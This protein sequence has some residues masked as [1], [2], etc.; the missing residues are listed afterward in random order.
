MA[1]DAVSGRV[2][3][4]AFGNRFYGLLKLVVGAP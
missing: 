1:S 4:G 3:H 2:R